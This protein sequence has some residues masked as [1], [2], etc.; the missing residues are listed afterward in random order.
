MKVDE[1]LKK[2]EVEI[3]QTQKGLEQVRSLERLKQVAQVYSGE[4]EVVP[5]SKIAERIVLQ[6]DEIKILSGWSGLD[7][8]LKGFRLQQLVTISAATKSGKTSFLMDLT[9]RIADYNPLWFP[10]EES[11]D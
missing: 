10:F 2:L 3:K 1:I 7:D 8:I 4:D 5:F 11:A 6:G 9:T